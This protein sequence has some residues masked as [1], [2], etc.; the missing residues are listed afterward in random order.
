MVPCILPWKKKKEACTMD[1]RNLQFIAAGL[2]M[3]LF[4]ITMVVV[5]TIN[6]Y[7][8]VEFGAG[9][10]LIGYYAAILALGV[11]AGTLAFGPIAD[12]YGYKPVMLAGVVLVAAGL[13]G[14]TASGSL[15]AVPWFFFLT[16]AGG[17]M[18]NGVTNVVVARIFPENNSAYLSL[19]GVFYG[20][21]ALGLPL[22]TSLMLENGYSYR[23]I[24][25]SVA[26]LLLVPFIMVLLL[27]FPK[28]QRSKAIPF[29]LYAG[30]FTKKAILLPGFF[31][32]FQSGIEAIVPVW[33]PV[34]LSETHNA[35]Y[36]KALYAI[37][38]A[39]LGM[40]LAR[41][42]L[43][44]ILQKKPPHKVLMVSL[45]IMTAAIIMLQ[46]AGSLTSGLIAMGII[47]VGMAA[48]FPVMMGYTADFFP[49]DSG[50][51]FS[52]VI[53]IALVGNMIL[54]AIT[55]YVLEIAG[56]RMF[57]LMLAI[58]AAA[59]IILLITIQ[60]K[61]IKNRYNVSKGMAE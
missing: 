14:V 4:G 42:V 2:V 30:F 58:F 46:V 13:A 8:T 44:R 12:H 39:A 54:N 48:A 45:L 21:G 23:F 24:L 59:L 53:A 3:M 33:A 32:F 31:L 6:N 1:K 19:L 10:V 18:L 9:K 40:L 49:E 20:G 22:I 38:A 15:Q 43:S 57:I 7:L 56:T 51:A 41:L 34:Y 55:G 28:P 16:G 26:S 27:K 17:G 50:T 37:T 11:L 61:L 25:T 60:N 5:G 35:G 29:K 52:I 36:D 47:G